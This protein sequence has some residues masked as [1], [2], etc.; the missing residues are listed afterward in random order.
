MATINGSLTSSNGW[1][2]EG[3]WETGETESYWETEDDYYYKSSLRG[4]PEEILNKPQLVADAVFDQTGFRPDVCER[5]GNRINI[6]FKSQGDWLEFAE[7]SSF[8]RIDFGKYF[9]C[10]FTLRGISE[11]DNKLDFFK[12]H[13]NPQLNFEEFVHRFKKLTKNVPNEEILVVSDVDGTLTNSSGRDSAGIEITARKGSI[14]FLNMLENKGIDYVVSSAAGPAKKAIHVLQK[15]GHGRVC[16]DGENTSG[17]ADI[18]GYGEVRYT[19]NGHFCFAEGQKALAMRVLFSKEKLD[20][21]KLII[22]CDDSLNQLDEH[23]KVINAQI[24][25]RINPE[26]VSAT[27]HGFVLS[28]IEGDEGP[29]LL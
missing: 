28:E 13:D 4:L 12:L 9:N 24:E 10:E 2:T 25:E 18:P 15:V 7:S 26:N 20:E 6:N 17:V 14:E 8:I 16:P 3:N 5:E 27:V 11:P 22:C 21:K 29:S 19:K 1:E 23:F